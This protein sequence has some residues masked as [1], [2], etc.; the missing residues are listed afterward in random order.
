[1]QMLM[2]NN[3]TTTTYSLLS[4]GMILQLLGIFISICFAQSRQTEG[5]QVPSTLVRLLM[6]VPT[7]LISL[8]IMGLGSA[9]VVETVEVSMGTAI[10]M[11]F[12]LAIGVVVC[13]LALLRG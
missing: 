5:T 6:R 9:F 3:I 1:M 4:F 8:G 12:F 11:S 7:V 13:V 2:A 10:A